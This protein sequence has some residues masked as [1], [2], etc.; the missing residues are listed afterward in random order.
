VRRHEQLRRFWTGLPPAAG[1]LLG[2]AVFFT[3]GAIGFLIDVM[4]N[5][6]APWP[7]LVGI[8]TF[9]GTVAVGYVAAIARGPL[10]LLAPVIAAQV[11][12]PRWLTRAFPPLTDPLSPELL[13]RRLQLDAMGALAFLVVGYVFFMVFITTQGTKHLRLRTEMSLA[14]RIHASL[15]PPIAM[16]AMGYEVRGRAFPANEVG[17]DLVDAVTAGG[18]LNCFVVDV[19]GHGVPAGTLMAAIKSAARMRLLTG[20]PV[21]DLVTDLNAV[22]LQIKEPHM[23]AT[24]A[25]LALDAEGRGAYVLAGH[26]ALLCYQA[27]RRTIVR[28]DQGQAALGILEG[29]SFQ[30]SPCALA[31][32]DVLVI[33]TD[34]LI[35]VTDRRDRELG[36]EGIEAVLRSSAD[37]PLDE[38]LAAVVATARAHGAQ[39]DDQTVLLVRRLAG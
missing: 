29:L 9:S 37:R 3:F 1:A 33:V 35:E 8:V 19:S 10:V 34:G 16:T 32:G 12:A 21:G 28:W 20:A 6:R 17:G 30:A 23:F 15:A 27:T 31:P 24:A 13:A 11:L 2:L 14:Q 7:W 26:P 39:R 4:A 18:R 38:L 22:L 36:L 25:C 5:G